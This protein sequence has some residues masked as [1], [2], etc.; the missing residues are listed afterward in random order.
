MTS[1]WVVK[2]LLVLIIFSFGA[3]WPRSYWWPWWPL[4]VIWE[5]KEGYDSLTMGISNIRV[6]WLIIPASFLSNQNGFFF[7]I[8]GL[9]RRPMASSRGR[10]ITAV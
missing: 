5:T 2:A 7:C 3:R 8:H 4:D 10:G 9:P 1:S 6:W